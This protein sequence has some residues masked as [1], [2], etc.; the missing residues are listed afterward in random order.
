M[1]L[2][3]ALVRYDA[4]CR[5]IAA[6]RSV[7]EVRKIHS[8]AEAMRAF[9]KQAKN[10]SLEIDAA[11]IRFR[12]ERRVGEL[13]DAQR[14]TEGLSKG[15]A[16]GGKKAGPRG[17]LLDPRDKRPTLA[18]AGINDKHLADRARKLAAIPKDVF[19]PMVDEWRQRVEQE[20]ERITV[21]LLREGERHQR[22][23]PNSAPPPLEGQY[24]VVYADPPWAYGNSG[25]ITDN[26][27]YGRAARHYDTMSI[28]ALCAMPVQAHV[29]ADAVLF[30]WVT[31]PLLAE[32]WPVID[33]WGFTY[34]ASIVWD[35]VAHN[36]G[37]Y[38]SVRHEL[39]LI[40]T[41]G[42]CLPD[43]PTP[44]P[45]SVQTIKRSDIHSEKPPEFRTLIERL[46]D[47]PR[48]EL[49]ARA[50]VQ[51]WDTWGDQAQVVAEASS[52]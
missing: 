28:E 19:D 12:A 16:G 33:A 50:Q 43:R 9:A 2:K 51:G 22:R 40:C 14:A 1:D 24:R 34:K 15:A 10:R 42:A 21:H 3:V 20:T 18:E 52:A 45:D 27:A 37:H 35:K 5:A 39:L 38:V 23:R 17:S 11:E 8:M 26:D 31:S 6:A 47:G 44:M 36:F 29:G 46:Y 49:F 13:M 30:L 41:R 25:V 32:C 7:H 48:I 4:A